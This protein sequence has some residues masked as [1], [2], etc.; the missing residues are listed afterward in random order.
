MRMTPQELSQKISHASGPPPTDLSP[1]LR[2]LWLAKTGDWEGA[3][4]IAQDLPDPHGAWLHAHLHRQEGDLGNAAYWYRRG[5][6][7]T[8]DESVSIADEW[9]LLVSHFCQNL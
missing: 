4:D 7:V 2:T 1:E 9:E 6:Q 3:H 5:N 8:P